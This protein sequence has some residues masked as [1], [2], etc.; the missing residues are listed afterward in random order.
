MCVCV[1]AYWAYEY[2]AL[3]TNSC[4][5]LSIA[6]YIFAAAEYRKRYFTYIIQMPGKSHVVAASFLIRWPSRTCMNS[7]GI[8]A[9]EE[10]V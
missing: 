9:Y 6:V 5:L 3:I 7:E 4:P 8:T 2:A 1:R 10:Y